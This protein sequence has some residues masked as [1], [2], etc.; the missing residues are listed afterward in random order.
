VCVANQCSDNH[1]DGA[2]TDIDC[3]GGTCSKCPNGKG[4]LTNTDCNSSACD[5]T[6]HVCV[7]SQ[8][9]DNQK[10]GAETDTDCGGP[11]CTK[12]ATGKA[13]LTNTDCSSNACDA[14]TLAC[15][16]SQCT[17][18]H[19]DGA[20]T[21]IDC[22]GGTCGTCATGKACV[23]D[24]DCSTNACDAI[25][26]LCVSSQCSDHRKDGAESDVDCGGGTCAA[27]AVGAHCNSNSDCAPGHICNASHLCQ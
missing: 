5:A 17:D 6:N 13:C 24:S 18:H 22:G 23:A 12:C 16:A 2:E 1:K 15:V 3:G 26:L 14:N 8:C 7:S 19:K 25:S 27:C 11:T 9:L 4:C 21:D 20:E 10:D